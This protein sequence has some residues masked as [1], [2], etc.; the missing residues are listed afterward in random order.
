M[1][2]LLLGTVPGVQWVWQSN[3]PSRYSVKNCT[4][5]RHCTALT[6]H[7][8]V[9]LNFLYISTS[10]RPAILRVTHQS[11]KE[12]ERHFRFVGHSVP[13]HSAGKAF[14][15]LF[16]FTNSHSQFCSGGT[17]SGK[18]SKFPRR[19]FI[20]PSTAWCSVHTSSM[21]VNTMPPVFL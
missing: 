12:T 15:S 4:T 5:N 20:F 13:T 6:K 17:S 16:C 8:S 3:V 1:S 18:P 19:E 9:Y 10:I 11:F 7:L 21:A 2:P 14:P